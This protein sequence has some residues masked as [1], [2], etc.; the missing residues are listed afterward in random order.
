ME[1]VN[2][3]SIRATIF[4]SVLFLSLS[5]SGCSVFSS[6]G[7]WFS[8]GY[9]DTIAYFN[10]YYN[11]KRLF[12]EA[13][14]EVL[15]ARSSSRANPT[16]AS[17]QSAS[18]S[19]AKQKF[20][21]VIDKCSNVLS[22]YPKSNIVEDALFLIGKSYF[23]QDEFLKAERKFTEL[24]AKSPNGTLALESQLWL[25][26]TLQRLNRFDDASRV[27]E[28]LSSTAADAGRGEIA[29]EALM[30]LGDIAVSQKNTDG[31]VKQYTKSVATYDDGAMQ[32][33]AQLKIG[34]L[35]FSIPD[36]EKAAPAYFDVQKYSPDDY[37]LYRTQ[38]Q[39]AI[40]YRHSKGYD[41]SLEILRKLESDY[42]F[43][44]YRGTIRFEIGN[45]FAQSGKLEEAINM[46]RLVDTTNSKSEAG[47]RAAFELG[48]L[49]QYEIGSYVDARGAYAHATVGG[50][51]ELTLD[52]T[53]K[54]TALDSY[55]RLQ[56]Q[57][58][59]LDSIFYILDIDSMW[60]KK[61]SSASLVKKDSS[62]LLAKK[63]Y[64]ALPVKKD[65]LA[66]LVKMDSSASLVIKDSILAVKDTTLLRTRL[67]TPKSLRDTVQ[68]S[69]VRDTTLTRASA[70][71]LMIQKPKKD[72]LMAS[73]GRL[74]YLLGEL[75]YTDLDVPDSTFFW[76]NRSLKLG[77]DSVKTPRA[78]YVLSEVARSSSDRRYGEEEDLY[79]IITEKYPKSLY[80]EEARIALGYR[81]TLTKEDPAAS[82]YAVAESLMYAGRYQKA[83]DSLGRIVRDFS[84]SPLV[85]KSRYT[86]GWIYENHLANPDSALSQYKTLA[87][88][89]VTTKYGLAAQRRIPP[90]DSLVQSAADSVKKSLLDARKKVLADTTKQAIPDSSLRAGVPQ[91]L[92]APVDTTG[93]RAA[94]RPPKPDSAKGNFDLDPIERR[95]AA[96][97]DSLKNRRNKEVEKP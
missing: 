18:G 38:I 29:G 87:Q 45:T 48:M 70:S 97:I 7:G 59:K 91:V 43:L 79:W 11:A 55:F 85:P 9:D 92:K 35:Y 88:K 41:Q 33:A 84:D 80:A 32:A 26:K 46:Y 93:G 61:D 75:F 14:A 2:V 15:A 10:A 39:A 8:Q 64:P 82:V 42:R 22:F 4:A 78:L 81:P 89:Y 20:T 62:F 60:I 69:K 30:I 47:A 56:Q 31:A 40:A 90:A 53:K 23:Y 52:A 95:A 16:G 21:V 6:I 66:P 65:S 25:L 76:L 51:Q 28:D 57:F 77:L 96:G 68:I 83:L 44:D 49:Y 24:L 17:L 36:Y 37:I 74:A 27:G 12:D 50:A 71:S 3:R 13:E 58:F 73:L 19:T 63:E 1:M 54:V 86:M 72:T 34:D 5:Q 67:D 94:I